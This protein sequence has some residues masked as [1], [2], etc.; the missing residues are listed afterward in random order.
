MPTMNEIYEGHAREYDELVACEDCE[1]N[2]GMALESL[3]PP[4]ARVLE[5]GVGTGRVTKLYA[6]RAGSVICCDRSAHM[7][8]RARENLRAFGNRIE[9]SL[10]D[11]DSLGNPGGPYDVIIE[12]WS[13][14]HSAVA[15]ATYI[16]E[17]FAA[18][19][20]G[21]LGLLAP[22][23]SIAVIE[24]LGTLADKPAAPGPALGEFY[25]LLEGPFGYRRTVLDTSYRFGDREEARRIIGYFFGSGM[26]SR[27]E[28]P[29]VPEYTGLWHFRRDRGSPTLARP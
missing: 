8:E 20:A 1:G 22:E 19:H 15:H 21:L 3:V 2:L 6:E 4:G 9:Y 16:P 26:A 24:T 18:L 17:W 11:N 27:V 28:D 14:G 12:G 25:D 10:A 23:G 7:L 5:L 13:F 29:L